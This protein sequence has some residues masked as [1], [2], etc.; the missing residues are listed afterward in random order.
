MKRFPNIHAPTS[1]NNLQHYQLTT[2]VRLV[3]AMIFPVVMSGCESLTIKKAERRRNW[4]F[5]TVAL[6]KTLEGPLDCKEIQP[7]HPKGNQSWVFIG[8]TDAE[9]ETPTLWPTDVKSWLTGKDP[10]A[11]K[12]WGQ[13]EKGT[14]DVM[15]GWHHWLDGHGFGWTSGVGD[16]PRGLACMAH[17]I[18][19]VGQD[20]AAELNWTSNKREYLFPPT[21]CLTVAISI[22][23][24]FSHT[25]ILKIA[26]HYLI[27]TYYYWECRHRVYFFVSHFYFSSLNQLYWFKYNKLLNLTIVSQQFVLPQEAFLWTYNQSPLS[28]WTQ[29]ITNLFSVIIHCFYLMF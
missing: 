12:D 28:T 18:S 11:G 10:D 19:R 21:S 7:A 16:G 8:R 2:K 5:W 24:L 4:C 17:G 14:E 15:V 26:F 27:H 13:E 6:R 25:W 23:K 1:N 3:E 20:W 9:A 22:Q 29:A